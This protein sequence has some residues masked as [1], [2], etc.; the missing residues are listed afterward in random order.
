MNMR[1]IKAIFI[2]LIFLTSKIGLALNVHYCGGHIEEIVLAWNAEGCGMSM[3]KSQDDHQDVNITKNRCCQDET[4]FIQ[5]NQP[6]KTVN[7]EFQINTLA[8]PQDN[9]VSLNTIKTIL[10]KEVFTR[11]GFFV[12]KNKIFLL[13]QSLIFYG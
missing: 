3:K 4:I 10:P 6:Q 8:I 2:V 11:S 9:S 1:S 13:N 7:D 5:N 12:P